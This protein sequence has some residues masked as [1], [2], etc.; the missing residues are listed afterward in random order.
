MIN[1]EVKVRD[2]RCKNIVSILS[3]SF[4]PV[5]SYDFLCAFI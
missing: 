2:N 4:L 3:D 5:N 1:I